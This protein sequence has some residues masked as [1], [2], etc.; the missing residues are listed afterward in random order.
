MV[1][2]PECKDKQREHTGEQRSLRDA[3]VSKS[4]V[5]IW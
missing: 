5:Q 4:A 3:R 1:Q 2:A